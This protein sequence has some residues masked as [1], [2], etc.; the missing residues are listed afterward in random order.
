MT[1]KDLKINNKQLEMLL[2]L[3]PYD[4]LE[5]LSILYHYRKFDKAPTE[6]D[7]LHRLALNAIFGVKL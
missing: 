4:M 3:K 6:L 2:T 1:T 7:P 5:V